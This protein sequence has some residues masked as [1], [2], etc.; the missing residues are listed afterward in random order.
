MIY[1]LSAPVDKKVIDTG[2][3]PP[4]GE[5]YFRKCT[6]AGGKAVFYV[7]VGLTN[8]PTSTSEGSFADGTT[9]HS[10]ASKSIPESSDQGIFMYRP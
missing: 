9:L 7:L 4:R 8:V 5:C 1:A 3:T 2:L 6:E 10:S